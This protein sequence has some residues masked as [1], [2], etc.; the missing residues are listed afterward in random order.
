MENQSNLIGM[1]GTA[2]SKIRE[3]ADVNTI[4][5]KPISVPDG[6]IIIPVSKVSY[7][8][9]S[10]GSDL[11]GEKSD[12]AGGAGGG[13]N[14]TP[15]AFLVAGAGGVKLMPVSPPAGSTAERII[16]LV[17]S[18]LD[19]AEELVNKYKKSD[20]DEDIAF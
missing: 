3:M 5:G 12:F 9:G 15:I 17:P 13:V 1:M 16:E 10:G 6:T 11:G 20:N 19:K 14:I 2:L 18:M 4:V 7:G 8:F